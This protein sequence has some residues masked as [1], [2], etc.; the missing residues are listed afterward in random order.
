MPDKDFDDRSTWVGPFFF[1]LVHD[2]LDAEDLIHEFFLRSWSGGKRGA[3]RTESLQ[4]AIRLLR[5]YRER[6]R[7]V[8]YKPISGGKRDARRGTAAQILEVWNNL[9][10]IEKLAHVVFSL[11]VMGSEKMATLLKI[12]PGTLRK[13]S[14][15]LLKRL[16]EQTGRPPE[17]VFEKLFRN[18]FPAAVR[19]RLRRRLKKDG[20]EPDRT[21]GYSSTDSP[22]GRIWAAMVDGAVVRIGIGNRSEREWLSCLV[23][24]FA[25]KG[26]SDPGRLQP[27]MRELDQ[28]FAGNRKQFTFPYRLI[29]A[30][31]FQS[32]V[33]AAC[34]EIPFG[35][36][37]SYGDLAEKIGRP[38]ATRAVG[39]ALGGN[40]LPLVIPCHRVLSSRGRLHGFSGGLESKEKLLALEGHAGLFPA[41]GTDRR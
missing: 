33:L 11:P 13:R 7:K 12:T 28:Y 37:R 9:P 26:I 41:S 32:D 39:G 27:V 29:D 6:A 23:P 10:E 21:A 1:L 24:R 36:V 34:A 25:P 14:N 18:S 8:R 5:L 20:P 4:S 17:G 35:S 15:R 2:P 3:N 40:P 22:I 31:P 30:S 19:N 38:R 16:S